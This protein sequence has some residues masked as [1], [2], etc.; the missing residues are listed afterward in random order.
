MI[1]IA[2]IASYLAY[3]TDHF[4]LSPHAYPEIPPSCDTCKVLVG[5]RF[6]RLSVYVRV[7]SFIC[8]AQVA[9]F[10]FLG[11]IGILASCNLQKANGC[12]CSLANSRGCLL[13]AS[14]G[15]I[16]IN[17]S[18][19]VRVRS[20][21]NQLK[22]AVK[23]EGRCQMYA[24]VRLQCAVPRSFLSLVH[25]ISQNQVC[26]CDVRFVQKIVVYCHSASTMRNY[27]VC[28]I[29]PTISLSLIL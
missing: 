10:F 4:Y 3:S 24:C 16:K 29:T 17:R 13:P 7:G 25:E 8:A 27:N 6:Y 28:Y 1:T 11:H 21:K 15:N 20:S 19:R 22:A 2:Y 9:T 18:I 23:H 12:Q 5:Y 26:E 14:I